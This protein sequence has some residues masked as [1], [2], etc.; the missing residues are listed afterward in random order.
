M[1]IRRFRRAGIDAIAVVFLA[2]ARQL[3]RTDAYRLSFS[4]RACA[5]AAA[6]S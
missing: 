2:I 4:Q 6:A 1:L 3:L 5:A